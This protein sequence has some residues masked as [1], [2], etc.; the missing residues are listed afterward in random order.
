M[1]LVRTACRPDGILGT[2][3]DDAG[4]QLAVT[5]E[6]SYGGVPKL[7]SGA[8]ICERGRHRLHGMTEDFGSK[9]AG[10]LEFDGYFANQNGMGWAAR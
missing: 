2:L 7:P 6:H 1:R 5:L 4:Q 3:S 10:G 9:N 8:Y